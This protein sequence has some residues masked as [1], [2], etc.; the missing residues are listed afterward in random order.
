MDRYVSDRTAERIRASVPENTRRAYGRQLE[1]FEAWCAEH[2]RTPLP[3]TAETL[4]EFVSFLCDLEL[5]PSSIDQA[6]TAIRT[7]HRTN[8]YPEQPGTEG[9]R[10]VLKVHRRGR[11]E[12]GKRAHKA[13]T[14]VLERLRL[15]IEATPADSLLGKRDRALFV[16]GFAM[17]ARRSELA[18]LWIEDVAEHEDGLTILVRSSKTDQSGVG[19]EVH[20][21]AGVHS[22]TDPVR[23]VRR[24]LEALAELGIASGKLFRSV[25]R[26]GRPGASISPDGIN[27]AVRAGAERA[28]IEGADLFSAHGLRAGGATSAYRN[29][30]PVSAIA[31]QGRWSEKSTAVLGYIRV[32]DQRRNNPMRGIGL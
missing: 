27:K 23:V 14:I 1:R 9:A 19:A 18:G 11:A 25:D 7:Q 22:D 31:A 24:Y 5:G 12:A 26:H 8:G 15:M 2:G 20:I 30:A 3:A 4:T 29:G 32:E 21:P 28:G 13:P 10:R 17:M 16:V 6:I